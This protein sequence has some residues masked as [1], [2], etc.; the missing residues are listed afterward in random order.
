MTG[1]LETS[2]ALSASRAMETGMEQ[3]V[4]NVGLSTNDL[5]FAEMQYVQQSM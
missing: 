3:M 5:V 1:M 2:H 4:K